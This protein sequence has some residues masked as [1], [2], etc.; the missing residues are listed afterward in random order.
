MHIEHVAVW[1]P[2]V[3]RLKRFYEDYFGARAGDRYENPAKHF[4]SYFLTFERG[5]RLE[6]MERPDIPS[7][8][9]DPATQRTGFIHLAFVVGDESAVAALTM[10][11]RAD[12]YPLLD[13]P[14]RTGDGYYE[15]VMLDPD[16]NRLE[17]AAQKP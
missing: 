14:R 7:D 13:G 15:S 10:R 12:G 16:G 17:I 3:E 1:K 6:L 2:N 9:A 8:R 11:L 5:A 4:K